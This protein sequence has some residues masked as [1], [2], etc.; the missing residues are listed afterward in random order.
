MLR[1]TILALVVAPFVNLTVPNMAAAQFLP[2]LPVLPAAPPA[3]AALPV[4]PPAIGGGFRAPAIGRGTFGP[5]VGGGAFR[6]GPAIGRDGLRN[7]SVVGEVGGLSGTTARG[8]A[9]SV[10]HGN[11]FVGY[12]GYSYGGHV[13]HGYGGYGHHHYSY[14]NR[15]WRDNA[16]YPYDSEVYSSESDCYTVNRGVQ[17]RYGSQARSNDVCN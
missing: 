8:N 16:Y 6:R 7:G 17:T 9:V 11:T 2:P 12:G 13:G 3:I 1:E 10:G 14:L 15:Y 5:I 4:R